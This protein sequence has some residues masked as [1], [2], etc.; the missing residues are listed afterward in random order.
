MKYSMGLIGLIVSGLAGLG[1]LV[2]MIAGL[3]DTPIRICGVVL[4]I[5]LVFMVYR[6]VK[7]RN[8]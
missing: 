3:G 2:S 5:S 1:L 6:L 8:G 4:M 7:E